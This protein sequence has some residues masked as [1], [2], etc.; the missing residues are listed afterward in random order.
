MEVLLAVHLAKDD[1]ADLE[2]RGVHGLDGTQLPG[3]DLAPHRISPRPELNGFAALVASDI[4]RNPSHAVSFHASPQ[5][6]EQ[7]RIK[8][9]V[10]L[11]VMLPQKALLQEAA[12]L[13]YTGGRGVVAED[14]GRD[15]RQPKRVESV[16]AQPPDNGGHDA[17]A[18]VWLRQ[19]VADLGAV[20][21]ADLK[22]LEATAADQGIVFF[23]NR[24]VHRTALLFR[25]LREQGEPFVGGGLSV[26]EGDA[27][28]AVVDVPVVEMRD[29]SLLVQRAE[30]G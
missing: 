12:L 20:G 29:E 25:V 23:A 28:G 24:P 4:F 19:P 10:V 27:E 18:P 7:P 22:V 17:A 26:G 16:P 6:R 3:V 9:P 1:V 8:E 5:Q 14:V 13:E 11:E 21:L 30:L 2:G 15:L